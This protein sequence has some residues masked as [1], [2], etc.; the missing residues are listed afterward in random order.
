MDPYDEDKM[1]FCDRC[2]RGYHTFCVGLRAIP[3]GRWECT[4][5]KEVEP[6]VQTTE[7]VPQASPLLKP[8]KVKRA[9]HRKQKPLCQ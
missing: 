4:S 3:T 2:D 8:V 5:C 9:Y 1:M 7:G 6:V